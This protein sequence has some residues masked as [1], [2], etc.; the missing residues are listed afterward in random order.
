MIKC[1]DPLKSLGNTYH[2]ISYFDDVVTVRRVFSSFIRLTISTKYQVKIYVVY[3]TGYSLYIGYKDGICAFEP[4]FDI[5][6]NKR[7][8]TFFMFVY[9][10]LDLVFFF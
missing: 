6:K 10:I 4:R 1:C 3:E 7:N 9:L 8:S 5:H 2:N